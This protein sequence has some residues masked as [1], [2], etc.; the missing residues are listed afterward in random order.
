[1]GA[2]APEE[3]AGGGDEGEEGEERE[4]VLRVE[5]ADVGGGAAGEAQG[6]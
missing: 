3:E 1:M 4:A 6:Q 2:E 5:G